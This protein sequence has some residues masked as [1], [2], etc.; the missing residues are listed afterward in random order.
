VSAERR[1]VRR[2]HELAVAVQRSMF[3][4]VDPL[5]F[6][7]VGVSY[8][9]A[10]LALDVGG[11]WY[12]VLALPNERIGLVVGDVAGRNLQ[13]SAV[14]GQL[15]SAIRAMAPWCPD[16]ATLLERADA[17]ARPI[18]GAAC[19]TVAYAVV[20]PHAG[21][22]TYAC[23]GHPPPLLIRADG[24]GTPLLGGRGSP[25]A[26]GCP[27]DAVTAEDQLGPGDTLIL[28]TDGFFPRR[29]AD[30][31]DG[32]RRLLNAAVALRDLP[33]AELAEQLTA[34]MLQGSAPHDDVCA[35]V[36]RRPLVREEHETA[37][38]AHDDARPEHQLGP[39][40]PAR[41]V[42]PRDQLN[43]WEVC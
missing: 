13:A 41:V 36:L 10:G 21:L 26:I 18:D 6:D 7:A 30:V 42:P 5:P 37:N 11:D 23:A 20:D 33:P 1:L 12:D 22:L 40:A 38:R 29:H 4:R 35:L 15:R 3:G 34:R 8:R 19:A 28:Y 32:I 17:F 9:S 14:M 43:P 25:L 39:G 31:D 2:E 27:V 24:T 16:A